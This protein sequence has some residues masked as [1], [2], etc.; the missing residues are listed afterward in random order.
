MGE[1]KED[2]KSKE[3]C[4]LAENLFKDYISFR[5]ELIKM[6]DTTLRLAYFIGFVNKRLIFKDLGF[7]VITVDLP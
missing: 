3:I 2:Y 7:V 6:N 4:L 5:K 1:R